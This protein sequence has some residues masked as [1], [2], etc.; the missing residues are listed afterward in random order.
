MSQNYTIARPYARAAF[1]VAQAHNK[2]DGWS[3][4]LW[5]GALMIS[6]KQFLELVRHPSFSNEQI[7]SWM[8]SILNDVMQENGQVFFEILTDSQRLIF[9][10]EI[11][12]LFETYKKQAQKTVHATVFSAQELNAQHK[13]KITNAL[14]ARLGAIQVDLTC[15]IDKTLLAGAI[16]KAGDLVIDGSAK[17]R[18][19]RLGEAIGV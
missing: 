15:E 16:I 2:L 6:N 17:G 8:S 19:D 10:P 12:E 13:E 4:M 7:V 11:F 1:E 14:K 5:G 3:E 9:L 18:L